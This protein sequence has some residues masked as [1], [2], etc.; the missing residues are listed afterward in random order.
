MNKIA[1]SFIIFLIGLFSSH[2]M[3]KPIKVQSPDGNLQVTVQVSDKIYYSIYAGDKLILQNCSLALKLP[4]E[5]LGENPKLRRVKRGVIDETVKREIPLKNAFV[6]NHC[7]TLRMSFAGNY[8]VEFRVFDTGVAYR[9]VLDKKDEIEV[10]N[11]FCNNIS[12]QYRSLVSI[13]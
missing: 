9:F 13:F 11:D 2:A 4:N 1:V 5:T 7:N 6:R 8:A 12:P 10:L 3:A